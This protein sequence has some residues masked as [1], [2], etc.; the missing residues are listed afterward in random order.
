VTGSPAYDYNKAIRSQAIARNL[1][2][3]E[4][5]ILDLEALV[6]EFLKEA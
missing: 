5:K 2:E 1:P 6:K 4:K 3:L